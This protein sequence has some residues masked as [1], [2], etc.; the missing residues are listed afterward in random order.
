MK[1]N[2]QGFTLIEL[3]VVIAII[4]V[5]AALLL[6]SYR[7]AQQRPYDVAAMQCGRAIVTAITT[8]K[9]EGRL[10]T[11]V[12]YTTLGAD[13]Q[14]ACADVQV[15]HFDST[16]ITKASTGDQKVNI[17]GDTKEWMFLTWSQSGSQLYEWHQ[18]RKVKGIN[19]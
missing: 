8:N 7:S 19:W 16:G 14:E 17:S 1:K 11:D 6:P 10:N 2:Q 4:G 12:V 18:G 13:V 15:H 5:L 9:V 3:L